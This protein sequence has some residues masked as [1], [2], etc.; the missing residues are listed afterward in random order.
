MP[1][2]RK[3]MDTKKGK[4]EAL[5]FEPRSAGIFLCQYQKSSLQLVIIEGTM[6]G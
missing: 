4:V 2:I 1:E 6:I 3:Q 5:G